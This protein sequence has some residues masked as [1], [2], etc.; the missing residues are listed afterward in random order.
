MCYPVFKT[1][2]IVFILNYYFLVVLDFFDILILKINFEK[3]YYFNI[4]SS[5]KFDKLLKG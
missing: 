5:K 4:F 3:I 2:E 1:F